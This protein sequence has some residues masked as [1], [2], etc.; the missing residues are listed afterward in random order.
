MFFLSRPARV[1]AI[2]TVHS[3]GW[4]NT[5][6]NLII[7]Q[8]DQTWTS[9]MTEASCLPIKDETTIYKKG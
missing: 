9:T 1:I 5:I 3:M 7:R 6:V 4:G 8:F 2:G